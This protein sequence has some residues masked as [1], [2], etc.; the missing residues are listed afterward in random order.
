MCTEFFLISLYFLVLSLVNFFLYKILKNY[1]KKLIYLQRFEL[2]FYFPKLEF[3]KT[4]SFFYFTHKEKKL[5]LFFDSSL[6]N[7][8]DLL[9][10][11]TTYKNLFQFFDK[12]KKG[13]F[14][15]LLETQYLFL[16]KEN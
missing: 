11:G 3:L 7:E 15:P 13:Y 16:F 10:L 9:I 6:L 14:F 1:I 12:K 4:I 8:E 5:L 2:F